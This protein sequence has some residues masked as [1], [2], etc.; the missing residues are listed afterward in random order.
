MYVSGSRWPLITILWFIAL[1]IPS[2]CGAISISLLFLWTDHV[3]ARRSL[4]ITKARSIIAK[5]TVKRTILQIKSIEIIK[6]CPVNTAMYN[7]P[8]V[9]CETGYISLMI[10]SLDPILKRIVM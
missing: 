10:I 7:S 5:A 1:P 4:S 2:S 6:L 9:L 8:N 3:C